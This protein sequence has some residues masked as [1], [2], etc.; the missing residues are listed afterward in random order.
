[1]AVL[2]GSSGGCG[3][4]EKQVQG[5]RGEPG[6]HPCTRTWGSRVLLG[7]RV[8]EWALPGNALLRREVTVLIIFCFLFLHLTFGQ[9]LL[10]GRRVPDPAVRTTQQELGGGHVL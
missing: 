1:M 3:H 9:K 6:G 7:A 5:W 4:G 2:G 8:G 10:V